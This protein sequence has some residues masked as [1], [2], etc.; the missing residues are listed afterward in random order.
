MPGRFARRPP[1]PALAGLL[2]IPGQG[3][4][5]SIGGSLTLG[6]L[7]RCGLGKPLDEGEPAYST[8]VLVEQFAEVLRDLAVNAHPMVEGIVPEPRVPR[9][10]DM[11]VVF[12]EPSSP[13]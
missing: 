3:S 8:G 12:D 9:L 2:L 1:G 4:D 13:R 6:R 7:D 10:N 5:Q 11:L